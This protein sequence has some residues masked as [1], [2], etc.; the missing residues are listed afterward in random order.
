[1]TV[2]RRC[3]LRHDRPCGIRGYGV[4]EQRFEIFRR[5]DGEPG[6][7]NVDAIEMIFRDDGALGADGAY[8]NPEAK[9]FWA[10]RDHELQM[11]VPPEHVRAFLATVFRA[12]IEPQRA[13][14]FGDLQRLDFK[15]AEVRVVKAFPHLGSAPT[16]ESGPWSE[17]EDHAGTADA[18][19]GSYG[20]SIDGG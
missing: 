8:T 4:T 15:N 13:L 3:G 6:A 16:P 1:M 5:D 11:R 12:P 10:D 14:T 20:A 7:R 17:L 19:P 2:R 18:A 9:A